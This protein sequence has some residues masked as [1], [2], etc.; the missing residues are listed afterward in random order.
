MRNRVVKVRCILMSSR[1]FTGVVLVAITAAIITTT[2][3]LAIT[4]LLQVNDAHAQQAANNTA[5]PE[6]ESLMLSVHIPLTGQLRNGDF[7]HLMDFTPFKVNS[8]GHSHIA[9]KVPYDNGGKPKVTIIDGVAPDFKTV[10]L[11]SAITNGTLD[12]KPIPLSNKGVSCL[13]HADIPPRITDIALVNTSNDTLRFD[14]VGGYGVTITT[15]TEVSEGAEKGEGGH[16]SMTMGSGGGS[17][18]S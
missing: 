6:H 4:T 7:I 3:G 2:A 13:Y 12:G 9:M 8:E 14:E 1:L 11:E 18:S 10:N 17:S 16:S 5:T 15:H